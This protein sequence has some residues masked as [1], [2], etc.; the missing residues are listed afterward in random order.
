MR[1]LPLV[2]LL[3]QAATAAQQ[4]RVEWVPNPRT[5]GGWVADPSHHLKR[6]TID[7]LNAMASALER[8]TSDEMAIVV[9][10]STK[11]LE[12]EDF[13]LAIHRAWGVG[14]G[15][16]DNGAVVLWVPPQ[17]ALY[18]SVGYGLEG[19]LIDGRVGR[20]RDE[21]FFPAFKANEFDRG[22]LDGVAALVAAARE[23]GV[24]IDRIKAPAERSSD[25]KPSAGRVFAIAGSVI[26]AVLAFLALFVGINVTR[27][28]RFHH[29]PKCRARMR[30]I[31]DPA[32]RL[33]LLDTGQRIEDRLGSVHRDFWICPKCGTRD[34]DEHLHGGAITLCPKCNYRTVKKTR[35]TV[36]AAT[37]RHNGEDLLA[38]RCANCDW[39]REES[40]V[41]PR[42]TEDSGGSGFVGGGGGGGGGG[43]SSGGGG[44]GSFGG[45]SAGGG[46]AGGHY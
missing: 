21:Q 19:R 28:R 3:V 36:R 5:S 46:G 41:T 2:L 9:V 37:T 44:G 13:A 30:Y 6:A 43:G 15:T 39:S 10:D 18:V 20:I 27:H 42:I 4:K 40:V 33:P 14:K 35:T 11:G 8:E 32:E 25:A 22:M 12:P 23:E 29:C 45:G 38:W 1:I 34:S 7:S 26:A 16:R 31:T 17:R 24:P